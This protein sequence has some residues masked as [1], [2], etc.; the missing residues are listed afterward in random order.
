MITLALSRKDYRDSRH[1]VRR[2]TS[3]GRSPVS[4]D[5][6]GSSFC[7]VSV[8]EMGPILSSPNLKNKILKFWG[9]SAFGSIVSKSPQGTEARYQE[10]YG[11]DGN[12]SYCRCSI[13][14]LVWV[15]S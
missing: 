10:F 9:K 12:H 6:G 15:E 14:Y 1:S 13:F 4:F 2:K 5:G 11:S 3:L 7:S 8:S